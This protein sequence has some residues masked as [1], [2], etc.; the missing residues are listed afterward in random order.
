M[1]VSNF[2]SSSFLNVAF[3]LCEDWGISPGALGQVTDPVFPS[4]HMVAAANP[5][6]THRALPVTSQPPTNMQAPTTPLFPAFSFQLLGTQ[7]GISG[8]TGRGHQHRQLI[9]QL[10]E[11]T[12]RAAN[13]NAVS[14]RDPTTR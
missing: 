7:V 10:L 4:S 13:E 6:P 2:V 8:S 11:L 1:C 3:K 12:G 5:A 9:G 14:G